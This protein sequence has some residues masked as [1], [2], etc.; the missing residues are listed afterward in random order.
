MQTAPSGPLLE[1]Q[2]TWSYAWSQSLYRIKFILVWLLIFPL[3][4]VFHLFFEHIEKREGIVLN[5]WLLDL[6]PVHNVSVPVFIFI[7]GAALL[8]IIRCVKNPQ[9]LL[10]L[11]WSYLLVSI[12][13]ML[14]I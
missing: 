5:D 2:Y 9:I 8:A 13:R 14:C 12:S 1:K 10:L 11:L 7:W 4:T 3:L 6:I